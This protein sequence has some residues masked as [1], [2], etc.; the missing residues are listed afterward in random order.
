MYGWAKRCACL[1][2]IA[3]TRD[4]DLS[5]VEVGP[6]VHSRWHTLACRIL[7]RYVPEQKPSTALVILLKLACKYTFH[8]GFKLNPNINSPMDRK[9][10]LLCTKGSKF[11]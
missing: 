1:A 5:M 6:I 9:M 7:R 2:I 10:C 8:L 4:S 11:F 3:G